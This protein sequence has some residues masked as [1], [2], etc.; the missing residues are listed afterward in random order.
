MGSCADKIEKTN[1]DSA[2][3]TNVDGAFL[4]G[5]FWTSR[6][7]VP[8]MKDEDLMWAFY[9]G[10]FESRGTIDASNPKHPKCVLEKEYRSIALRMAES[11][12][13]VCEESKF[14]GSIIFEDV[15]AVDLLSKMY[16]GSP[17]I[18][19]S[20]KHSTYLNLVC[21]L[22]TCLFSKAIP[23]AVTP[24]KRF[25]SDEGYDLTLVSVDKIIS[26]KITRYE[27]G[28]RVIP[29]L[30]WHVELLPRSSLSSSGYMLANSVGLIDQ[31]YRGTL[32]VVLIKV[33][34]SLPDLVLPFKAV[35]MVLRK[36]IHYLVKED[37]AERTPKTTRGEGGFGS[38]NS[39]HP[40]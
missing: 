8:Q 35:Q 26:E 7:D 12:G 5:W 39:L 28:V 21:H 27:T 33:D 2:I 20:E 32:K 18:G 9:R 30:G 38:T 23:E 31:S 36:S 6:D 40:R 14:D 4:M 22:P 19:K 29:E 15:N 1:T 3:M 10:F 37:E 24:T 11:S 17:K 34:S 13:I 16:D 25:S